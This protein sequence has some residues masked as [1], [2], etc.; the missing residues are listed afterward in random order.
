MH[1]R[2]TDLHVIHLAIAL[3]MGVQTDMRLQ[4]LISPSKIPLQACALPV[5]FSQRHN[6]LEKPLGL[7]R[8]IISVANKLNNISHNILLIAQHFSDMTGYA[9]NYHR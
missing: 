2:T 3:A 5:L 6:I 7:G 8:N 9:C 4:L 1:I